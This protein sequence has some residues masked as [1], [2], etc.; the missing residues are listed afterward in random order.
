MNFFISSA[1]FILLNSSF[2]QATSLLHQGELL[3]S[4]KLDEL[5]SDNDI[6]YANQNIFISNDNCGLKILDLAGEEVGSID[7]NENK[8]CPSGLS[9]AQDS[10][11][12][13]L[14]GYQLDG[15]ETT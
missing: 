8:T 13:I 7:S 5:G 6:V 15:I 10:S 1:T 3:W 4:K 14:A 9:F 12:F 2:I 11:F